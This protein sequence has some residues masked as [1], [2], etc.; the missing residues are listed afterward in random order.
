MNI[1]FISY[2]NPFIHHGGGEQITSTLITEGRNRGHRIKVVHIDPIKDEYNENTDINILWDI[3]NCPEKFNRFADEWI[4]RVIK[5]PT[6]YIYGTGGYEDLCSLGTLP[7]MGEINTTNECTV[8]KD[9]DTFGPGG[10]NRPF[11]VSCPVKRRAQ[12]LTDARLC[13]FFSKQHRDLTEQMVGPLNSLVAMPPITGLE[14]FKDEGKFRD[15]DLVSYGGHL[16][17]KGFFNI[18]EAFPDRD[19]HFIGD[20]PTALPQIYKFGKILGKV[21]LD[22]MPQFLNRV[23]TF[24]HMPRWPEPFG[25]TTL[26][27]ALCGC[28]VIENEN[29]NVL[30]GWDLPDLVEETKRWVNCEPIWEEIELYA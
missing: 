10:I 24:V 28:E 25:M 15:I 1:N 12:L 14:K 3:Y 30:K 4:N 26:Q 22:V 9:H 29:S 13:I 5:S 11:P 19:V 23:R 27:A 18:K 2:L 6:P 17:Y 7:C 8:R 21:P 16:E 20:G